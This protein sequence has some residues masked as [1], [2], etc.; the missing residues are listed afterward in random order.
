METKFDKK[1]LIFLIL[2]NYLFYSQHI[3]IFILYYVAGIVKYLIYS[4]LQSGISC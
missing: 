2:V 3:Q 4:E 1:K